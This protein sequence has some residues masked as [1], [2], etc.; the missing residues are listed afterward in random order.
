M[1]PRRGG[2]RYG[3]GSVSVK[4]NGNAYGDDYSRTLIAFIALFIV[5]YIVLAFFIP[6][7]KKRTALNGGQPPRSNGRWTLLGWTIGLEIM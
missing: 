7:K 4:C 5:V 1:A 6:G 3:G 2:G